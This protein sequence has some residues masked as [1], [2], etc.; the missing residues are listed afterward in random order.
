MSGAASRDQILMARKLIQEGEETWTSISDSGHQVLWNNASEEIER[1][2]LK[3]T[4]SS[5]SLSK[6]VLTIIALCFLFYSVFWCLLTD[7]LW[8]HQDLEVLHQ[9]ASPGDCID[10]EGFDRIWN[11]LYPVA[12]ALSTFEMNE[13]WECTSP[14]WIEGIITKEEAEASLAGPCGLQAPGT[15]VLR[16]PSSRS[17]PHPDAG[18]LVVTYVGL[19]STIR[20]KLLSLW[21]ELLFFTFKS[22]CYSLQIY[23]NKSCNVP[24][25]NLEKKNE[26]YKFNIP[27]TIFHYLPNLLDRHHEIIVGRETYI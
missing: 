24:L 11:W 26:A 8:F 14:K 7:L 9:M 4:R 10:R 6:E 3:I 15:F 27:P 21:Y 12:Y 2:F 17:W 19:D 18:S 1:R 13:I 25:I 5:R 20:H 16:F 23:I 22:I